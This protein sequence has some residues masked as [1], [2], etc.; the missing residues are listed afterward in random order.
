MSNQLQE[1][2]QINCIDHCKPRF[3]YWPL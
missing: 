1:P 2:R 3:R